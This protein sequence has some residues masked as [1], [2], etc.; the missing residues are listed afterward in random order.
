MSV[1]IS[2]GSLARLGFGR[3]DRAQRFLAD[4]ALDG[5]DRAGVEAIGRTAD[6]DEALIGLLRWAES[7]RQADETGAARLLA[8]VGEEGTA[9]SRLVTLLGAS[10][11]LGDFLTRHP[12]R[13]VALEGEADGLDAATAEVRRR[14]LR[15]VG[16]DPDAEIP[17]A[18][19]DGRSGRDALRIAYHERLVQIA[20]ADLD[21]PDPTAVQPAVS[22]ALADLADAALD[23]A[24]A[25]ARTSV[26]GHEDVRLAV[27][28]MGKTGARE[29]NYISDVD[30]IHVAEPRPGADG[31]SVDEEALIATASSL[32]RELARVCS[33]R[34]AE[35]S[36]WQVDAN[37]R[38]EGKDGPLAR[39]LDSCRRYYRTWAAS[40]EFQALLKARPAAGDRDLGEAFVEMVA[41]HV[42]QAAA[43]DG[44]VEDSRAMRRRVID[45]IPRGEVERNLK[46]GP[47]GLRDV[48]FTVQMLQMVHGRGDESLRVRGTLPALERLRD[49][50]YI[51]RDHAAELDASYRFL[52]AVEHRLQLHRMRRTHVL[53]T[54]EGDLRCLARA[55]GLL[56]DEFPTR[57]EKVRRRVRRLHEEIYYRP[58]LDTASTLSE[59][60]VRLTPEAAAERLAAIGYRDPKRALAH[61]DALTEGISRRAAIQRQLLPSLLEWFADG[62]DPDLGLLAFRRLSDAVGSA[63]WYMG[64]LR[65]SGVAARR[66]TRVLSDSRY[67]GEQLEQIPEA[68]RWLA[69]DEE[70]RPLGREALI[71][72]FAAVIRRVDTAEEATEVLRR[73]RRRELLRIAMAHL[74]HLVRPEE[75]AAALTDL[76]EAVLEA[77]VQVAAH[78]VATEDGPERPSEQP[79]AT[80]EDAD[81]DRSALERLGI[82]LGV[83]AMGSFGAAEMGYSSDADVQFVVADAG[84]GEATT[85]VAVKVATTLQRILNAPSSGADMKV[86]ADLRPEGRNGVLVRTIESWSGHYDRSAETWE[87]QAL[88]RARPIVGSAA[89][90]EAMRETMD[91][92][93][94]PDGGLTAQQRRDIVRMK[95]RVES[96]RL[97][98]GTDPSRHLKLGRGS[99]TDVEWTVQLL[100]MDSA[101]ARPALRGR[102][103]TLDLLDALVD[104]DVLP[105]RSAEDLAAAWRLAWELRRALFLW[106]GRE[107]AILPL[108]RIELRA[109]A[110]VVLGPDATA[111]QVEEEYLRVTRHARGIVE[112]VFFGEPGRGA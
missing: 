44:F 22:E 97:P 102:T 13:I 27:L 71:G 9:G 24:L 14:L 84:A 40:W 43:R 53:P 33:D 36:L 15:A 95:A 73:T 39:T 62:V 57:Y 48:E 2:T 107:S 96:E 12:D 80:G 41:P 56:P 86:S 5:L 89:L 42:W 104:A 88:L 72:E 82:D 108:D 50:G 105:R 38:P 20:V 74:V 21:A 101:S 70:L 47:G 58:L 64:L 61:I 29:L 49:G 19:G 66:L 75:V 11:A 69:R 51:G 76:A 6:P 34:T 16:A 55:L 63:H 94:Y 45:H 79:Q 25:V 17:V 10:V 100:T 106:R 30:V 93:R 112:A 91:R 103:E 46:L 87:R 90:R 35:G 111:R 109:A 18:A 23:A 110:Q 37:L 7:A 77:G 54:S 68:V 60:Q 65:D 3:T 32:A 8:D 85:S 92:H 28:A 1:E 26:E 52:R 78:V 98:R 67:A 31:G 4:P 83:L 81:E 59:D 99:M